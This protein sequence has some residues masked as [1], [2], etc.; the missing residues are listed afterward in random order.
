MI[1][2]VTCY[3]EIFLIFHILI[4]TILVFPVIATEF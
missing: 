2:P 1:V 4:V 3:G